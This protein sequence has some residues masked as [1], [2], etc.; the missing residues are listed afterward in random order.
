MNY[1]ILWAPDVE[2][3]FDKILAK[4]NAEERA[5]LAE[6]ARVINQRLVD[7]PFNFGESRFEDVR[8]GF[9]PPLTV[10]FQVMPDVR[11]VIV[12]NLISHKRLS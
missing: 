4:A 5:K 12:F 11:T 10:L 1:R 7:D 2:D 6:A 3:Y 8:I 9:E